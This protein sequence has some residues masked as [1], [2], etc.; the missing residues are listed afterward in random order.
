M[1]P[2]TNRV[3]VTHAIGH[4]SGCHLNPAVSI[5]LWA[6]GRFPASQGVG[7]VVAQI[8]EAI[9][10]LNAQRGIRTVLSLA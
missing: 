8:N 3:Y 9:D 6:G 10:D 2:V 1:N 5:G 4:I 7:A